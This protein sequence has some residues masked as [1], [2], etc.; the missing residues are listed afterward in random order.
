LNKAEQFQVL[1]GGGM[2]TFL[3]TSMKGR[4]KDGR[5]LLE[6]WKTKM[7]RFNNVLVTNST[8]FR[9]IEPSKIDYL[10]GKLLA[11]YI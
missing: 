8:S 10:F 3:P 6:E 2:N 9:N 5:N 1:L 7:K 11:L 4:R